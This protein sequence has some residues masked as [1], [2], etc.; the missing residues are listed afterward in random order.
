MTV[1]CCAPAIVTYAIFLPSGEKRGHVGNASSLRK[2][3]HESADRPVQSIMV[4][5]APST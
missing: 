4:C 2:I 5:R 1:T 3:E